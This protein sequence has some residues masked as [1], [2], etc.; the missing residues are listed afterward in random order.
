MHSFL[1]EGSV[2]FVR[3]CQTD[4][5]VGSGESVDH[6]MN[7]GRR[8][9]QTFSRNYKNIDTSQTAVFRYIHT[10]YE[11]ME[12]ESRDKVF[13]LGLRAACQLGRYGQKLQLS[14]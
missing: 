5:S 2:L 4:I 10:D 9:H 7:N 13:K 6:A 12:E 8:F 11:K 3:V 14:D 1:L